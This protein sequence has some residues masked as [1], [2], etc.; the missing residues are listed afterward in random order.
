[1]KNQILLKDINIFDVKDGTFKNNMDILIEND[2]IENVGK[3]KETNVEKRIDCS[4]KFAVPGLFDCH[5]H[6]AFLTTM[7]DNKKKK[8]LKDFVEKG[9]TQIRDVGGPLNVLKKLKENISNGKLTGP[10]IFYAGP[11]LE[12]SPLYWEKH[13]KILPGFTVAINTKKDAR[14]IIQE[15][16][17]EGASLVKTF[18]KFDIDIFKY[19]V[20]EAKEHSLP[21]THD[22]GHPIFHHI[23]MD[24]AIGFGV[25][26][27]EHGK[28]PWPIVLK[29]NLYLEYDKVFNTKSDKKDIMTFVGKIF[30]LGME[31]I[32]LTKLQELIDTM[33]QNNVYFCPTLNVFKPKEEQQDEKI[34]QKEQD[35]RKKTLEIMYKIS[36]FFTKEITKQ[37]I[38]ILIGQDGCNPESTF[39]EMFTLKECG[40][41]ESE[42]IKGATI[43]PSE[44]LGITEKF[45]SISANK[46]A[47]ILILNKNPLEDIQNIRTSYMV[48]QNGKVIF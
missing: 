8:M 18:N 39:N 43:Y 16:S 23:P 38:K 6:I 4:G 44:W 24:K 37:N 36:H 46:K 19:L 2:L 5:T 3:I 20:S 33:V 26:C 7:A 31:S 30:S 21:V 10:E 12:K 34:S 28:S 40:L 14:N 32:S 17:N 15:L 29:N 48:L 35:K 9:I 41:S 11:M 42:I 47:N 13:N 27:F 25:K 1:M 22:P 45:G